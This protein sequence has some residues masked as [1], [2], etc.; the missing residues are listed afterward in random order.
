[1][2]HRAY[3]GRSDVP[4]HDAITEKKLQIIFGAN[5]ELIPPWFVLSEDQRT[6]YGYYLLPPGVSPS[7]GIA[8]G[9]SFGI[10]ALEPGRS[11][12]VRK[13]PRCRIKARVVRRRR[14]GA[15]QP[16][17]RTKTSSLAQVDY[18]EAM[19]VTSCRRPRR[20]PGLSC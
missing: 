2:V 11:L 6:K 1:V 9:M 3:I 8:R 16:P 12:L 7:N 17:L 20:D 15:R 19:A 4:N 18:A 14:Q 13:V 5:P 10:P